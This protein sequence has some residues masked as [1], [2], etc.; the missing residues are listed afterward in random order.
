M[1]AHTSE[2]TSILGQSR[3]RCRR[4]GRLLPS[5]RLRRS[6]WRLARVYETYQCLEGHLL[7]NRHLPLGNR[8]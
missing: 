8:L 6:V 1:V 3:C 2:M 5:P 7:P 4:K